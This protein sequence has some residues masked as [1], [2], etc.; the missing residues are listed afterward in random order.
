[1]EY[2]ISSEKLLMEYTDYL[3]C[4]KDGKFDGTSPI[5]AQELNIVA[6]YDI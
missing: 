4:I 1:M 5:R 3:I 2:T 6:V